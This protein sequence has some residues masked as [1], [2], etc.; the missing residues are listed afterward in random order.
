M[1]LANSSLRSK[2][3]VKARKQAK[4]QGRN[5]KKNIVPMKGKG[6]KKEIF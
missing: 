1:A 6:R 3:K 4:S 5:K 2:S